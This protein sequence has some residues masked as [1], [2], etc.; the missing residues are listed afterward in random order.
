VRRSIPAMTNVYEYA[1][2]LADDELSDVVGTGGYGAYGVG[3]CGVCGAAAIPAVVN[4]PA[5]TTIPV[6][7]APSGPYINA[8]DAS[9]QSSTAY[10]VG[11][12]NSNAVKSSV[13]TM[14]N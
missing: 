7:A 9:S 14:I 6:A 11:L 3:G 10:N 12:Q 5:V 2:E 4:I 1:I 13:F 8:L